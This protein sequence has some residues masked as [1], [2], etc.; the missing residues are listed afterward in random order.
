MNTYWIGRSNEYNRGQ[1]A[2]LYT[3]AWGFAQVAGPSIG[4]WVADQY[5]FTALWWMIFSIGVIAGIGYHRLTRVAS[6][7]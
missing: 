4:G 3:M 1:Y 5:S 2:A 7:T 6:L